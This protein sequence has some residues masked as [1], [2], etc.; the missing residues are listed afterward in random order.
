MR[1]V[2]KPGVEPDAEEFDRIDIKFEL[3]SNT[4]RVV[5]KENCLGFGARDSEATGCTPF[6]DIV[7]DCAYG[8]IEIFARFY[9][10][11]VVGIDKMFGICVFAGEIIDHYQER[12]SEMTEP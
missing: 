12:T 8:I 1:A 3:S 6:P 9:Y 4:A 7:L 5:L 2:R 10:A 11:G